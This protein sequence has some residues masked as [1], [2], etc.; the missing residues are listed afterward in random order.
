M[1]RL[2]TPGAILAAAL[3]V[4]GCGSGSGGTA[5]P[6]GASGATGK[7]VSVKQIDGTGSVLVDAR[8][9]ALYAS[10][11][12]MSG[13]VLCTDACTSFWTPLTISGGSPSGSVNGKLGT[14]A[15]PD[16]GT[17]VTLD[18]KP[19]YSFTEDKPGKVSGDGFSDAFGGQKFTWHVV[20]VGKTSGSSNGSGGSQDSSGYGY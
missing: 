12:E 11:Q 10:D 4:A 13:K 6:S 9:A 16:G 14:V 2:R 17:Q 20:A 7:T 18:K 8:G 19:L 15:R 5:S 3:V 1:I